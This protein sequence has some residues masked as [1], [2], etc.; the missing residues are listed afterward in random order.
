MRLDW[1]GGGGE[2]LFDTRVEATVVKFAEAVEFVSLV[3]SRRRPMKEGNG[4]DSNQWSGSGHSLLLLTVCSKLI[5]AH[6][7]HPSVARSL[8]I[9]S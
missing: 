4:T 2:R 7:P 3:W 5:C 9:V 8:N 1:E 6:S